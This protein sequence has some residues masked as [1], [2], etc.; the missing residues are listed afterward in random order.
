MIRGNIKYCLFLCLIALSLS[1]GSSGQDGENK[2]IQI[3]FDT[4]YTMTHKEFSFDINGSVTPDSSHSGAACT[5]VTWEGHLDKRSYYGFAVGKDDPNPNNIFNLILYFPKDG[6]EFG[7]KSLLPA[8][9]DTAPASGQYTAVMR[10]NGEIYRNPTG[11]ITLSITR[12]TSPTV[13]SP[14]PVTGVPVDSNGNTEI[15]MTGTFTLDSSTLDSSTLPLS[16][17]TVR[18]TAG[19]PMILKPY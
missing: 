1:C 2:F 14:D 10:Y 7:F 4:P 3:N 5:A 6:S 8:P 9:P 12:L 13:T 11:A 16:S 17:V 18:Q 19:L 15:V